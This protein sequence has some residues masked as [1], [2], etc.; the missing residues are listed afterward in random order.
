[1]NCFLTLSIS[2]S[3]GRL[4]ERGGGNHSVSNRAEYV[5]YAR[6]SSPIAESR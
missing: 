3:F 2:G 5:P 4:L 6:V 1:M